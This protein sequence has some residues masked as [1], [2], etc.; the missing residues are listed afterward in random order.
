M[1]YSVLCRSF[2]R[3]RAARTRSSGYRLELLALEGRVVPST[4]R[5][6]SPVSGDRD[7]AANR[8]DRP[9]NCREPRR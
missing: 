2:S 7:T 1:L 3:R 8:T 6:V 4:V 9:G 5:W